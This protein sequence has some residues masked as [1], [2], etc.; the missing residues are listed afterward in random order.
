VSNPLQL[1]SGFSLITRLLAREEQH[2]A[3]NLAATLT[4]GRARGQGK[5]LACHE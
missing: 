1:F 3:K 2:L 4:T 5:M